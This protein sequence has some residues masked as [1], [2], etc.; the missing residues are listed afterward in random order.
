M[1]TTV[2]FMKLHK[3]I[4]LNKLAEQRGIPPLLYDTEK[5]QSR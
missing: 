1:G 5:R 3:L 4:K 2:S